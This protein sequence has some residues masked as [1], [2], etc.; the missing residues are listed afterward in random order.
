MYGLSTFEADLGSK[1][2]ARSHVR[3]RIFSAKNDFFLNDCVGYIII[4]TRQAIKS[5]ESQRNV[6]TR[7]SLSDDFKI[8]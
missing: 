3:T 8:K 1:I 6:Y 5:H 2:W 7:H 4:M